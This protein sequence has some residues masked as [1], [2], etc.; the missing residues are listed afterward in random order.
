MK[1]AQK[2]PIIIISGPAG[3]GKTT[4]AKALQRDYSN[5][6]TSVTYTTR[7]PRLEAPED[8]KIYY[9]TIPEFE[10]MIVQDEFLE[11]AKVHGQ[12]Y[13]THKNKTL[14]KLKNHPVIFNLDVQ[15]AKQIMEKITDH[16]LV[17][18]FLVPESIE[19]IKERIIKR[20]HSDPDD[21]ARRLESAEKE[22][23]TQNIYQHQIV[24]SEGRVQETIATIKKILTPYLTQKTSIFS[25]IRTFLHF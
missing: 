6:E 16:P 15:G 4:V 19:Q 14:E 9:I 22:L 24:N 13:G 20:G 7:Q 8:K 11:W 3:V 5:L 25:Q 12:Y 1:A 23:K 2:N 21:L 18:I 10:K 17:S